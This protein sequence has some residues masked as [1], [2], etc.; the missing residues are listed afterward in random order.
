MRNFCFCGFAGGIYEPSLSPA[1]SPAG[2]AD[3]F[4]TASPHGYIRAD[5]L[6]YTQSWVYRS[7]S[8]FQYPATPASRRILCFFSRFSSEKSLP[9]GIQTAFPASI[10]IFL[11][12]CGYR[13]R[14]RR[15]YTHGRLSGSIFP[16]F[17]PHLW[18]LQRRIGSIYPY[19]SLKSHYV[20]FSSE[21]NP[22]F[23]APAK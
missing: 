6:P 17:H 2:Y 10:P 12:I 20:V 9:V 19:L 23:A 11:S 15:L 1:V 22:N 8:S 18:V 16:Y 3:F 14:L 7:F 13:H 4:L 5:F 21:I